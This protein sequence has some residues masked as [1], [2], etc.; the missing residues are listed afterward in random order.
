MARGRSRAR[1]IRSGDLVPGEP[2]AVGESHRR[3]E[4]R[5]LAYHRALAKQLRRPMVDEAR[6]VLWKWRDRRKIDDRYAQQWDEVLRR[7]IAEIRR[8][9]SED[10]PGARD[11]RQNSPF[12]GMLSEPERRKIM[13]EVG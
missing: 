9:I 7:P 5:S 10:S 8:I 6:H 2:G 3:A 12:G 13:R 1:R 11:L 4:L